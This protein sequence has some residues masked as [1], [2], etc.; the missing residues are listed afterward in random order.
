M[1]IGR[2][3]SRSPPGQIDLDTSIQDALES[4]SQGFQ[5]F[6]QNTKSAVKI[7]QDKISTQMSHTGDSLENTMGSLERT[8]DNASSSTWTTLQS[9][10]WSLRDKVKQTADQLSEK[11]MD[12]D[13]EHGITKN[14]SSYFRSGSANTPHSQPINRTSSAPYQPVSASSTT[15]LPTND[16]S[17]KDVSTRI[18]PPIPDQNRRNEDVDSNIGES[19]HKRD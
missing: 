11:V 19:H 18:P 5:K 1:Y 10:W 2:P 13:R 15:E 17:G 3:P 16:G 6:A 4:L 8:I 12:Y 7:M 14:V 9:S